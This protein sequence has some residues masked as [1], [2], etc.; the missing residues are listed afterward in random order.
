MATPLSLRFFS[1]DK[2]LRGQWD[3]RV[4]KARN[5]LARALVSYCSFKRAHVDKLAKTARGDFVLDAGCG[6]GAYSQW[7]LERRPTARCI[8]IDWSEAAL[9]LVRPT[10]GG[11]IIRVCADARFLPIKSASM[12]ALFSIDTLGHIENCASALDEF[13]RVCKIGALLFLHSECSDYQGK[14]P[15]RMLIKRL[16]EDILAR[17]DGHHFIKQSAELY[18]LYSR[19]FRVQSFLNPA[20]YCGFLLGY[21][22]KYRI[23][24]TRA[25]WRF[26]TIVATVFALL[27]KA[28]V[29]GLG[30]RLLNAFSN[31]A[32]V[33]FGLKGGGSCFAMMKKP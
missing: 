11:R 18:T 23:A 32:E 28:P 21:P 12:D 33:F 10:A 29:L 16:D 1:T 7:Y 14:W 31:H 30:L 5:P 20:G 2:H 19:R 17:Y 6:K 4:V 24:F 15:D 26:L 25:K 13:S 22:E 27:K 8:A 3:T 9:R